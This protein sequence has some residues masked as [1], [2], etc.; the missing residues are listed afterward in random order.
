MANKNKATQKSVKTYIIFDS[1]PEGRKN[2]LKTTNQREAIVEYRHR[3]TRR[4][5]KNNHPVLVVDVNGEEHEN[6]WI[7]EN[8][9]IHV[10]GE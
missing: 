9:R 6:V 4:Y 10:F 5:S 8:K 2:I 1:T 7:E 3:G